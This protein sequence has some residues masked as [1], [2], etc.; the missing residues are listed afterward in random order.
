LDDW[1]TVPFVTVDYKKWFF[2]RS[3]YLAGV[4]YATP[5]IWSIIWWLCNG[6]F[7]YEALFRI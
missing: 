5:E 7:K 1:G 4:E 2:N 6:A 3:G